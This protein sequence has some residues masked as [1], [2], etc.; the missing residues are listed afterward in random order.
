MSRTASFVAALCLVTAACGASAQHVNRAKSVKY[1]ADF[2][3]VWTAVDAEVKSHY[4]R[5]KQEDAAT[6]VIV[7]DWTVIEKK[8]DATMTDNVNSAAGAKSGDVN[9]GDLFQARVRIVEGGPPWQVVVEGEA[10]EYRPGLA[11][12]RPYP[13]GAIDEP[14][15]V[16]GRIDE[17]YLGIYKRLESKAVDAKAAPPAPAPAPPT[18]APP[19]ESPPSETP[20]PAAP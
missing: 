13:R 5:I 19:V 20:A 10:A 4:R 2:A 3:E 9:A 6:G 11:S 12:L 8:A 18:E 16:Q 14:Q 1:Q 17:L 15:W 7:T